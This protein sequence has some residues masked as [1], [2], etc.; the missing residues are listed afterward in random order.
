MSSAENQERGLRSDSPTMQVLSPRRWLEFKF[1][2]PGFRI[3]SLKGGRDD[4]GT[5]ED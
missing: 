2:L 4:E 3:R 1:L 5:N